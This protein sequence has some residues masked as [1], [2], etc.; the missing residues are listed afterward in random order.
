MALRSFPAFSGVFGGVGQR[1]TVAAEEQHPIARRAYC[2]SDT[3]V[4][5]VSQ[6]MWEQKLAFVRKGLDS[7]KAQRKSKE[8]KE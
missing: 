3:P 8:D 1:S 4:L 7:D 6:F 5:L 2:C